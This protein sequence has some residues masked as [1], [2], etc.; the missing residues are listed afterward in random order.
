VTELLEAEII[1]NYPPSGKAGNMPSG[2]T[3]TAF[4]LLIAPGFAAGLYVLFEPSLGEVALFGGTYLLSSLFLSPDLDLHKNLARRRWGPLGFIW[5]PYSKIFKHRGL[6]HSLLLGPITRL[7]YLGVVFGL[8]LWG[9]SH[10]GLAPPQGSPKLGERTLFIVGA[11][12]YLP[13]VLHVLLDR[14]VSALR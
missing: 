5:T 12:L 14:L 3:H 10:V 2:R 4:E 9:L 13:N 8:V 1:I 6:S 7:I 11:G